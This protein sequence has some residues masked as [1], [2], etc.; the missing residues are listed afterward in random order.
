MLAVTIVAFG[1]ARFLG[2]GLQRKLLPASAIVL[3]GLGIY[4]L[5]RVGAFLLG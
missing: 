2:P 4:Q 5:V 1:G 3:A